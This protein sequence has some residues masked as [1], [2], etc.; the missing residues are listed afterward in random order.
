[1]IGNDWR[2]YIAGVIAAKMTAD[3]SSAR[4][5]S[6]GP[7]YDPAETDP[8][9]YTQASDWD[10]GAGQNLNFGSASGDTD[11]ATAPGVP[12]MWT[13]SIGGTYPQTIL[14]MIVTD[15]ANTVLHAVLPFDTPIVIPSAGSVMTTTVNYVEG[16]LA[17]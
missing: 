3:I 4:P 7:T 8:S 9:V 12:Q 10:E 17:P 6:A 13:A 14:G 5:Y 15:D 1:M 2:V 11:A 16:Q